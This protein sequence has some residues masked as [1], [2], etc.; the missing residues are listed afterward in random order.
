MP[1]NINISDPLVSPNG[2]INASE[3]P[4]STSPRRRGGF[5]LPEMMV[6]CMLL[7]VFIAGGLWAMMMIN[8]RA[9]VARLQTLALTVAQQ[10]I[11]D[12]MTVSWQMAQ[13]RPNL[14][15]AGTATESNLPLGNDN[16]NNQA[17][18][19]SAYTNLDLQVNATRTTTITNLDARSLRAAVTVTFNYRGRDY[20]V[21]LTSL[22]AIDT[23]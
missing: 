13:P 7:C 20:S 19:S 2:L 22:R 4:P 15:S 10:R 23:I 12:I 1:I 18:L 5:T 6:A 3:I 21:G 8:R 17:G 9:Q 16:L 11:D 14:L